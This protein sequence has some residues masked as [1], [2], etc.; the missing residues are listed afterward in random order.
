MIQFFIFV[1]FCLN[2]KIVYDYVNVLN[3]E[4]KFFMYLKE[5]FN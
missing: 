5:Y 2:F 4:G 3:V 1:F